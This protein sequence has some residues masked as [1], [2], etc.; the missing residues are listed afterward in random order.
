[1][2]LKSLL[3]H[4]RHK[5]LTAAACRPAKRPARL[6]V[7]SLE[8]R[9]VP[10]TLPAPIVDQQSFRSITNEPTAFAPAMMADPTNPDQLFAAYVIPAGNGTRVAFRFSTNGGTTWSA[11]LNVVDK[12]F[13]GTHPWMQ[14]GEATNRHT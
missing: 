10:A 6:K 8:E 5:Y 1:M 3:D 7:E 11:P 13:G 9:A 4:R 12:L 2:H 14:T